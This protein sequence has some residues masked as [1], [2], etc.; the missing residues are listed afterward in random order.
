MTP[1]PLADPL[2]ELVTEQENPRS[3]AIASMSIAEAVALINDE[4]AR[5]AEAVKATLPDVVRAV[6]GIVA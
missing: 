6:E 1:D 5:V 2:A 3:R 4:D